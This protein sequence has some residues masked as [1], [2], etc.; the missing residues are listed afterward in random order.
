MNELVLFATDTE[1]PEKN[2][3][4]AEWYDNQG[5]NASA[6]TYY[7]RAA[8]RAEDKLLAY[9]SLL[10]AAISY[11]KQATREVT[12][13]SLI[14]SALSILPER[15]EAYYFLCLIYEKKQ[16]WDQVYTYSILGL[17][18]YDKE[19]EPINIPDYKGKYLLVYQK[20]I[21]S[22]WWGKM[23]ESRDLFYSLVDEYWDDMNSEYRFLVEDKIMHIG[24]GPNS[25]SAVYYDRSKLDQLRFKFKNSDTIERSYSQ[26]L[27]DIFVLSALDGKNNGTFLEIGGAKPFDRN[28]TALLEE[29]FNW[30]GV[31]IELDETFAKEYT[32]ERPKTKVLNQN[33]LDINYEKLLNE[34]FQETTIDYLQLDIEPARNTYECMLKIPFDKYKFAVITYEH[35]YYIDVTRLYRQKS[36]DFLESKGYVLVVNDISP[37]GISS[38]EDWWVHPDLVD[39][40]IISIMKDD[41]DGVKSV[42]DYIFCN[43]FYS[44]FE[45]DKYLR[46]NFFPDLGYKGI[47]VEVGAGPQEFISNS[48]HFRNYGWRTIAVEPNP[49]FVKQHKDN[50]SEVYQYACSNEEKETTFTINYNNDDWYSQENDGVSFS[51]LG[52]KYDNVPEHNTQEVI[53]V[54][55]IKLNTLLDKIDVNSIDI[56]SIDTEGWELEVMMGFDQEK[57]LPKVIVLENFQN[58]ISYEPFMKDRNYIKH[59]QLGYNEIYVREKLTSEEIEQTESEV[60]SNLPTAPEFDWGNLNEEYVQL[61]T[62]ENFI[63]RTYEKHQEVKPNDIVFDVGANYGS[64]TYSILDKKPKEVY[65]IEPSNTVIDFLRKNV[66]HGPVTFINKAISDKEEITPIPEN[67]VYIYDHEGN[68][69]STTTFE[70]IISE[71]NISKIDFLKFD[72]EGGEYSI[73]TKDN[74]EFIRNN[75]TNFAGEWHINDHQNAVERFIE[76]RNLYLNDCSDLHVY[77]RN[78]KDVT[79]DIFNDQY[80]YDFRD[81]WKLT[82]LGQFMIYF[83]YGSISKFNFM[84]NL[85]STSWIVDNFY[86]NPDEIRKFALEQEFDEGGFGRGFIGRRTKHQ[87]LFPNLKEKFEEIMGRKITAWQEHGMNGRFQIAWSGEPLVYHCDSQKWGGML[88]LTPNAPYQCGTTLY[89]HKQ[90][91]ARTYYEEGWDAA[92][93]NILGECHLDGTPWEPVD[94]L[95]NVYNRLVIFDASCIHSASEYFGT[96][97]ENARLWQM[98][99][100]DTEDQ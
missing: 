11:R 18:C 77:E 20:A 27:Q 73:F 93:T 33:A 52:I 57:Y 63:H 35:D 36:R 88:Y 21:S 28:N 71:Y 31:S 16:E 99:F 84:T 48:K 22:W 92:W 70:K 80:L 97:K 62:N 54:Q 55:T 61:F 59:S 34:N 65:C 82:C 39:E 66:S 13:K 29:K 4:L 64:F 38:F 43:K 44:E 7:L 37:D 90:T 96:T 86:D 60:I 83:S 12:E 68:S 76:F 3:N 46:E 42:E 81:W 8:E 40:K 9:T 94:V 98:F 41:S 100:F 91:R 87:F 58:N 79:K 45:T 51:S 15:P 25:Q 78:G 47:M 19:I 14:H 69:Y 5:H 72:C 26:V 53:E 67:G 75:V 56:L 30:R 89:A 85:K 95:G 17:N 1:N 23:K 49:K 32:N 2:Y 74:Y 6:H 10:R 24:L 50:N